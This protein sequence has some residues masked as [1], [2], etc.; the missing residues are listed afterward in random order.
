MRPVM[1]PQLDPDHLM[2][3]PRFLDSPYESDN[4]TEDEAQQTFEQFMYMSSA[5]SSHLYFLFREFTKSAFTPVASGA[6]G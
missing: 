5:L 2:Q 6:S 4:V 3:S 1:S